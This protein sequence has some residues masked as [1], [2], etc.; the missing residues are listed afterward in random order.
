MDSRDTAKDGPSMVSP[1][2]RLANVSVIFSL[3]SHRPDRLATAGADHCVFLV[4]EDVVVHDEQPLSPDE[5]VERARLEPDHV[6]GPGRNV[7]APRLARI[8][9]ARAAHPVV[10]RR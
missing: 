7:V 5:L 6:A 1:S 2:F 8:D 3:P 4:E 9:R 10:G